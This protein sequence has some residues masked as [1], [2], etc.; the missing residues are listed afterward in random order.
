MIKNNQ[1]IIKTKI[2]TLLLALLFSV[3]LFSQSLYLDYKKNDVKREMALFP[4][5]KLIVEA[6]DY[7]EYRKDYAVIGYRFE[8]KRCIEVAVTVLDID[9][10]KFTRD[11]EKCKCW[12]ELK[13]G[14]WVY[15]IIIN[16]RWVFV[17]EIKEESWSTFVYY[18]EE[19]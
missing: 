1:K 3:P 12:L 10:E 15:K 8:Q 19:K 9:K 14:G 7:L 17:K 13:D 11:K 18:L 4:D 16:D 6:K 5:C 2:L